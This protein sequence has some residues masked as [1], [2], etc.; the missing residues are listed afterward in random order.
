MVNFIPGS[1]GRDLP[2]ERNQGLTS[3]ML[4]RTILLP[5]CLL[6]CHC[7]TVT[8]PSGRRTSLTQSGLTPS[9]RVEA[10]KNRPL[11][12]DPTDPMNKVHARDGAVGYRLL[13]F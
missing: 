10:D 2:W 5:A 8:S 7:E 6:L 11:S 13:E 3:G 4:H 1:G 9:E 12:S